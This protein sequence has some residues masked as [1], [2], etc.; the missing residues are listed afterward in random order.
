MIF[1]LTETILKFIFQS[2]NFIELE[3][4]MRASAKDLRFYSKNILETVSRGEQVIITYRGKPCAKL[5]PLEEENTGKGL[6]DPLFGIWKD[7]KETGNVKE[8]V[9][10]LRRA[11]F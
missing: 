11:R 8:Y 3:N 4:E 1:L 2:I 9:R 7:H 10:K 6:D 5:V